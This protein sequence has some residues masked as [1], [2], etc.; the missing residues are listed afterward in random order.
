MDSKKSNKKKYHDA[1][2]QQYGAKIEDRGKL[3]DYSESDGEDDLGRDDD[4]KE[5]L[6][7]QE[8]EEK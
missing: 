6:E 8:K 4:Q 7:E 1:T 3:N 5:N 2:P